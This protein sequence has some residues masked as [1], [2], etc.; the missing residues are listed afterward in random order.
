MQREQQPGALYLGAAKA[1]IERRRVAAFISGMHGGKPPPSPGKV[2]PGPFVGQ[3]LLLPSDPAAAAIAASGAAVTAA[4]VGLQVSGAMAAAGAARRLTEEQFELHLQVRGA[5]CWHLLG[6]RLLLLSAAAH[7]CLLSL[8]RPQC[9]ESAVQHSKATVDLLRT[10]QESL[11]RSERRNSKTLQ[12]VL[13]L[14]GHELLDA[15]DVP[16]AERL[17]TQVAAFYRRERWEGPL[18]SALLLLRECRQHEHDLQVGGA[19]KGH[20]RWLQ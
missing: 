15:G 5:E 7:G 10:A 8:P 18:A 20:V 3:V 13:L 16:G 14:L 1:A 17:L 11:S 4:L 2:A 9:E 19:L 12:H 6:P